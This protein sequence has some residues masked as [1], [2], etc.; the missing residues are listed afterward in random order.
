MINNEPP[1]NIEKNVNLRAKV[2]RMMKNVIAIKQ[3]IMTR[4]NALIYDTII[5]I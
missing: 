3:K 1:V 4:T 2:Q 5:E